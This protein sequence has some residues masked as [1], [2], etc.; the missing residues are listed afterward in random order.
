[1]TLVKLRQ[2]ATQAIRMRVRNGEYS[3]RGLARLVRI[4]QPQINQALAG[5]KNLSIEKLDRI[6][7][8]L[9]I[10]LEEEIRQSPRQE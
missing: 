10:R 9:E 8:V 5:K 6:C 1:M 2:L 7:R 3:E 4:S